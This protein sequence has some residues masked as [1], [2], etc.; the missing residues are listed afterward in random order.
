MDFPLS[1]PSGMIWPLTGLCEKEMRAFVA[2]EI[3]EPIREALGG[4]IAELRR[5][6]APIKWVAPENLHLTLKFLGTVPDDLAPQAVEILQGCVAGV[7]P[8]RLELKGTGAFPN[9]G[10]PRVIFVGAEDAP[11]AAGE[12]ARRLDKR[13]TRLGVRRED[14]PFRR[15]ITVGRVRKPR[16]IGKV[17]Q[18]LE[19]ASDRS[20][21][22]MVARNVVL[23]QSELTP[24]GPVYT[25]VAHIE[26]KSD[27]DKTPV[28]EASNRNS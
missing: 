26:L 27:A 20:F 21:G 24:H 25:P 19:A 15:H 4:L 14:R 11:P 2:V 9:L 7:A 17:A 28:A 8:F 10:R 18:G 13:M 1:V 3:S 23:M 16:P 22:V 12:L 5:H 6:D